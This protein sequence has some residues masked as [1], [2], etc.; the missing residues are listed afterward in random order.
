MFLKTMTAAALTA[1]MATGAFADDQNIGTAK[2]VLQAIATGDTGFLTNALNADAYVQHNLAYPD[3]AAPVIGAVSS[4]AFDGT[5]IETVRAFADGDVVVL[6]SIYGGS[7]NGGTPQVAFDVF[8]FN[9][10]GTIGEHWDNLVEQQDDGDGTTQTD[11]PTDVVNMD[12]TEANRALLAQV[13]QEFFLEG[14]YSKLH[15]FFADDYVQHSVGYG[16]DINGLAGFLKTIPEGTPFYQ[17]VEYIHVDG[18]FGLMMSQGFPD[19]DSGLSSAYYDLFRFEGG[20]IAE[21]WDVVQ[22]IP[23]ESD[24]ANSNGKW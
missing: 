14:K 12:Q 7:W 13:G 20:K 21:H 17:S 11:G 3:G 22:V 8:R 4:G 10:D 15:E 5:T 18:N 16:P 6:H 24:W 2:G 9:D 23:A 1:L 19:K